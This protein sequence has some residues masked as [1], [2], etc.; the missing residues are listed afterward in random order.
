MVNQGYRVDEPANHTVADLFKTW[1]HQ[2]E[3][4]TT[5]WLSDCN[6]YGECE[7]VPCMVGGRC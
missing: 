4:M 7:R 3:E 6:V 5:R 1:E 2:W